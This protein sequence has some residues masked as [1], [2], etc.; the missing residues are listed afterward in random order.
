MDVAQTR[1]ELE[2]LRAQINYHNYRYYVL[3]DPE[4]SDAAYDALMRRLVEIEREHPDLVEPDS[5]T[6]R[7]GAR[8]LDKFEEVRHSVPMLSL[9]NA[10]EEEEVREFDAR[11]KRFL[12]TDGDI[13]YCAELKMDGVAVELIYDEG[14]FTT[15][16]TRGD[17]FVGEN[18]TQNLKTV[19]A[20]PLRLLPHPGNPVPS[21]LEVRGEVYLPIKAFR[22]F[23]RQREKDGESLFA[24]PRNAAAGSLRQLDPSIT[25][26]RPL[27]IFCYGVGEISAHSSKTHWELLEAL[28]HW[29]I[30]VNPRR[31]LCHRIDEVLRFY[32]EIDA[33]REKLPYAIDGV[34]MKVNSL[35]LQET[36]GTIAR[37]P[38]WALA[39][40]FK[41]RQTTTKV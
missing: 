19:K 4:I 11:V 6:Q 38:R 13:E 5:P 23:N 15:G 2:R 25:A 12:K 10:F 36:L 24:N 21:R 17:G 37:S 28:S 9:G 8:P 32:R 33:E 1:A 41:Q 29:G 34:V 7:V 14:R 40:K 3:D 30:K 22:D 39:F 26:K 35:S 20:V 18:V 27:D 31:R 16:S